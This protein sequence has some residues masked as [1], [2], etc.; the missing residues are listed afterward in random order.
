MK[1]QRIVRTQTD[2]Q[3]YLEKIREWIPFVRQ[4]QAVVAERRHRD[5]NLLQIEEVLQCWDLAKEDTVRDRVRGQI[6]RRQVV[7]VTS[8]AAVRAEDEGVFRRC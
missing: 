8:F 3:P 5:P 7:W 2:V 6:R 1:L 4:E